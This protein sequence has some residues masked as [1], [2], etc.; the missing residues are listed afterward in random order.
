MGRADIPIID[1]Y[2]KINIC[3][4]NESDVKEVFNSASIVNYKRDFDE[5]VLYD[6]NLYNLSSQTQFS[7]GNILIKGIKDFSKFKKVLDIGCGN[8]ASTIELWSQN[9]NMLID[10]F[11]ISESQIGISKKNFKSYILEHN[12][13]DLKNNINFYVKDALT[14]DCHESY[15]LV[16]SNATLHWI[17]ESEKMYKKIYDALK[18][19]GQLA[20][21]Q[22]G[23]GTYKGLHELAKEAIENVGYKDKFLNWHFPA[24]YPSKDELYKILD[25]IG[26]RNIIINDVYSDESDNKNL[27]DNFAKASLIFYKKAGLST[28]DFYKIEKEF[29][30]LTGEKNIDKSSY[31]L[32]VYADK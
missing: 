10:A 27:I 13:N 12:L 11:D 9:K 23:K 29:L 24:F 22:G 14:L 6:G 31:R 26:F 4:K 21:H 28:D 3:N 1:I 7:Q 2:E 18:Y 17:L 8:G 20:I 16:F 19:N 30:R 5:I 32:Y 15:D 25:K